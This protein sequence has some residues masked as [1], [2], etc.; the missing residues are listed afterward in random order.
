MSA[1]HKYLKHSGKSDS[2]HTE[3]PIEEKEEKVSYIYRTH[4]KTTMRHVSDEFSF[5]FVGHVCG[6]R[7]SFFPFIVRTGYVYVS[8]IFFSFIFSSLFMLSSFYIV[9]A[10]KK[11]C[12]NL[13]GFSEKIVQMEDILQGLTDHFMYF[14][15][16]LFFILGMGGICLLIWRSLREFQEYNQQRRPRN[17]LSLSL[18]IFVLFVVFFPL[19][20]FFTYVLIFCIFS[21]PESLYAL[22]VSRICL[23]VSTSICMIYAAFE[24]F[25]YYQTCK[26]SIPEA[27]DGSL[28]LQRKY[29]VYIVLLS[30]FLLLLF[31]SLYALLF[32]HIYKRPQESLEQN[33][34]IIHWIA[35]NMPLF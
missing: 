23:F 15:G 26:N 22:S 19:V 2:E 27:K 20:A 35:I 12:Y 16:L 21:S 24:V 25:Y 34:P 7:N 28:T 10:I 18:A 5:S 32:F 1:L 9:L 6:C 29:R 31:I 4:M 30:A 14:E 13:E 8:C 3:S 33:F 11:I 17:P